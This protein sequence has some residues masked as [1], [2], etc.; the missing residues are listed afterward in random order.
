MIFKEFGKGVDFFFN[1]I[2]PKKLLVVII[3]TVIVLKEIDAPDEYWWILMAYFGVNITGN[4]AKTIKDRMG[5][6]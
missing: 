5:D 6:K 1:K 3:A 4:I 2:I